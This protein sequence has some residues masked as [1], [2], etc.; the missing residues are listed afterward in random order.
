M[1]MYLVWG[2]IRSATFGCG[3]STVPGVG[4]S[5]VLSIF[6]TTPRGRCVSFR[7]HCGAAGQVADSPNPIPCHVCIFWVMALCSLVVG[8]QTFGA[9][10]IL[11]RQY[12]STR[13]HGV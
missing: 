12:Q 6:I 4:R 7:S 2:D 10:F 1:D 9:P 3:C 8:L 11:K 13:L 5:V